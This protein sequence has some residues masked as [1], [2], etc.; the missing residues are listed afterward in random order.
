MREARE[1][2]AEWKI[3]RADSCVPYS[4]V[5]RMGVRSPVMLYGPPAVDVTSYGTVASRRWAQVPLSPT[6]GSQQQL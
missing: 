6:P 5:V 3:E 2:R 4:L 1:R